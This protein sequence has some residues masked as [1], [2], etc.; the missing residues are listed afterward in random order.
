MTDSDLVSPFLIY[1]ANGYTGELCAREAARRGLRPILAGRR[2]EPVERLAREL[3]LPSRIV[4]LDDAESLRTALDDVGAVLHCAGPFVRTARPMVKACLET[5]THYLDITGE[6]AVFE[7][8]QRRHETARELGV[9]LLPGVGFDVVPTDCLAARL[10]DQVPDATHLELAFAG[11]GAEW[12]RG[13]LNTMIESLPHMG[14]VRLDGQIVEVPPAYDT[15]EIHFP[16]LGRRFTMTIPWGDVS[17]AYASTGIPNIRVFSATPPKAVKR[18]KR[19]RPLLPIAGWKPVKRLI[20]KWV[21][22]TVTGPSEDARESARMYVWGRAWNEAGQDA[23]GAL[24]TPEGYTLT[25]LTS[26]E[27]ARRVAEGQVQPGAWTPSRA[28]GPDYVTEF[29][30]VEVYEAG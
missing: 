24:S 30:G 28:F 13:T 21:Q 10:A 15:R 25:A 20:Q 14:A 17:T 1:G 12:S 2:R 7:A 6:M 26:V 29:S 23:E 4:S 19:M 27:S 8:V 18:L 9:V 22:R 3:N 16:G 5:G 11:D